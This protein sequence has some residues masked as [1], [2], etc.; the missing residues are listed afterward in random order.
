MGERTEREVLNHLIERCHDAERGFR[1]AAD[2]AVAPELRQK[3]LNLAEQRRTF[4]AMLLPHA[5]RLG[6]ARDADGT[7]E[8]AVH[9]AWIQL[10]ARLAKDRDHALLKE[11]ERGERYTVA[12]FDDAVNDI[13]PPDVRDLVEAEDEDVHIALSELV[14]ALK[15]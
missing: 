14:A 9:R 2:E 6:G 8:A 3:F 12:A 11:A 1:L 5:Q 15:R 4:A 7:A 10:K 13:L